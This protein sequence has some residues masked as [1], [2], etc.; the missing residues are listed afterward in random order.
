MV[1]C[2]QAS[3]QTA[4]A[5]TGTEG[6]PA[7]LTQAD[8]FKCADGWAYAF[9]NSGTGEG[10]Y[11]QTVVFEVE[12]QFWIPKDRQKVCIAPGNQVPKAIYEDACNTN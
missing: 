9:V 2:D 11:T 4:V 3:I 1:E 10:Q 7:T 8:S 12:G 5:A 6:D